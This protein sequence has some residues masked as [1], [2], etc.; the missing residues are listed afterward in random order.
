M[1]F[2]FFLGRLQEFNLRFIAILLTAFPLMLL[3]VFVYGVVQEF[4]PFN[5]IYKLLPKN[6]FLAI[7]VGA[8]LGF[9]IPVCDCG[10]APTAH[11]LYKRGFGLP[12]T[13]AFIL[14]APVLN[15]I[16]FFTTAVGFGFNY[17]V[18]F[19]RLLF[20]F[21]VAVLVAACV[22][23]V[24][25]E[26][27]QPKPDFSGTELEDKKQELERNK[28]VISAHVASITHYASSEMVDLGRFLLL[29][30]AVAAAIQTFVPQGPVTS[31]GHGVVTSTLSLMVLAA[32]LSICSISDAPI[33]ASFLG[34]FT[35]GAVMAFMLFGQMFDVKNAF[36]FF[37]LFQARIV[38][39]MI[40]LSALFVLITGVFINIGW[41]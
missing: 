17:T 22:G 39:L 23:L 19:Y 18:A 13:I 7:P 30:A 20:T 40:L 6:K 2:E 41:L 29:G 5:K 16:V 25:D 12:G 11:G 27:L 1:N 33:A 10:V 32:L 4:L 24:I 36:M 3:G 35:P 38:S 8:L 37:R 31:I 14:G 26:Y 21:V 34:A 28:G 9:V 15:P